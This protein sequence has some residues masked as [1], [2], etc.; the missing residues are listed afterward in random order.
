M[1]SPFNNSTIIFWLVIIP[2]QCLH[3]YDY[4]NILTASTLI[5]DMYS[6]FFLPVKMLITDISNNFLLVE[7]FIGDVRN[8]ITTSIYI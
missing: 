3:N 8:L 4:N 6:Y 2:S 1:V 5:K 7:M